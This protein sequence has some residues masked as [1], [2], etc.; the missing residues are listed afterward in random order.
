[1]PKMRVMR[2]ALLSLALLAATPLAASGSYVSALPIGRVKVDVMK[3]VTNTDVRAEVPNH[4]QSSADPMARAEERIAEEHQNAHMQHNQPPR[5]SGVT[6]VKTGEATIDFVRTADGRIL[7]QPD[8]SLP[9]LAGIVIDYDGADTPFGRAA[10]HA[11]VAASDA[12][13][14]EQWTLD[15]PG[16]E[17]SNGTKVKLAIGTLRDNRRTI[18]TY[19]AK[20]IETGKAPSLANVVIVIR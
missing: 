2:N 19:E 7:L 18:L 15:A 4:K 8:G 1:M 12:W 20:S 11:D 3:S 17:P 9:E 10:E 16:E 5:S 14:G 13:S 6:L